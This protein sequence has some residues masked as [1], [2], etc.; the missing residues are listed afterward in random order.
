MPAPK[1]RTPVIAPKA[2]GTSHVRRGAPIVAPTM[3]LPP[4]TMIAM[5]P[6][7]KRLAY[8]DGEPVGSPTRDENTPLVPAGYNEKAKL[9]AERRIVLAGYRLAAVLGELQKRRRRRLPQSIPSRL[10]AKGRLVLS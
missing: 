4:P 1:S 5:T 9:T 3:P 6:R 2:T 7:P 8:L 10:L